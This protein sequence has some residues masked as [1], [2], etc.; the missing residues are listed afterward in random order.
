MSLSACSPEKRRSSYDSTNIASPEFKANPF[1]Y[2]ARLRQAPACRRVLPTRETAW[3]ITRYDD[4]AM[5]LKDEHFVKDTKNALTPEQAAN[6]PWF[7][8]VFKSLKRNL[9]NQDPPDH[10][11]LRG[12]FKVFSPRLIEQMR[13]HREAHRRPPGCGPEPGA[14]DL[15]RDYALPLP[16]TIIAELLGVPVQD[17]HAFH[18]GTDAIVSAAA[19]SWAMFRAIPSAWLLI[20]Y[21]RKLIKKRRADPR[22]DLIAPWPRARKVATD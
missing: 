1:P 5:V 21:I 9:L 11:R 15:I 4:V 10:T 3:L 16:A 13:P 20:R 17:R 12:L 22:D 18:R 2:Y 7:R 8:K 14:P 6:Q 19:S